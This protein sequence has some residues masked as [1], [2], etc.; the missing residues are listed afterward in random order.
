MPDKA[1]TNRTENKDTQKSA[2]ATRAERAQAQRDEQYRIDCEAIAAGFELHN[3]PGQ[4]I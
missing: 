1:D 4:A 2:P 3:R